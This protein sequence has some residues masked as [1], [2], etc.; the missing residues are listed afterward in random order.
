MNRMAAL[1]GGKHVEADHP[2][3]ESPLPDGVRMQ[4]S[5]VRS[6]SVRRKRQ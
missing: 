3:L 5:P 4:K 2:H 1:T 6:S